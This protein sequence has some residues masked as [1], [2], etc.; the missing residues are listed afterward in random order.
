MIAF[1]DIFAE[2]DENGGGE[3]K[4]SVCRYHL[5]PHITHDG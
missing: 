2:I 1:Y 4:I 3:K 5:S